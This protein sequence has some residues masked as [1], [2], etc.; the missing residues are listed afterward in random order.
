MKLSRAYDPNYIKSCMNLLYITWAC[1][2]FVTIADTATVI[3]ESK[4]M[5]VVGIAT[6][7][8]TFVL[9]PGII[10][11]I[12]MGIVH[13]L[14]HY[15]LKSEK[16]MAQAILYIT[17][18]TIMCFVLAQSN[19]E[20]VII[21]VLFTIPILLGMLYL[22]IRVQIFSLVINLIAFSIHIFIL[23]SF[24]DEM[25]GNKLFSSNVE[26]AV[27]LMLVVFG[28]S[29]VVIRR[30]ERIN[31]YTEEKI[32]KSHEDAFSGFP[33][34]SGFYDDLDVVFKDAEREAGEFSLGLIDIDNFTSLNEEHDFDFGNKVLEIMVDSINKS[35][36]NTAKAYRYSGEEFAL[37]CIG[38]QDIMI[39]MVDSI[40]R[41]FKKKT[42]LKLGKKIT[43]SAGV[44]EYDPEQFRGKSD[45]FAAVS[46]AL[47]ASKRL[48]KDR[49]AVW[50]EALVR[51]SFVRAGSLV[52]DRIVEEVIVDVIEEVQ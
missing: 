41:D 50:N 28:L 39:N 7:F 5:S 6:G 47:Y 8:R 13:S 30:Y 34:H 1:I 19:Q 52:P 44:C 35:L 18:A 49:S 51:D 16:F 45:V 9:V 17:G 37:I 40:L 43:A 4:F 31:G 23:F 38:Q 24:Q 12:T 32:R 42:E 33:N 25:V 14:S 21:L 27:V 11:I 26:T 22:D 48:G 15:F 3:M 29:I 2:A 36:V 46:E 20:T 10:N